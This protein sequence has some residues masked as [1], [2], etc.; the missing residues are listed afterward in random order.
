MHVL[1]V[2]I[3]VLYAVVFDFQFSKIKRHFIFHTIDKK[4][5]IIYLRTTTGTD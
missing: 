1:T 5:S 2:I 3:C 4:L